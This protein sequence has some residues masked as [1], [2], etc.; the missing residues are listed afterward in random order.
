M[1]FKPW[2]ERDIWQIERWTGGRDDDTGE[3]W[4]GGKGK[5]QS[6]IFANLKKQI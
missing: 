5:G 1:Y 2:V 4:D 3:P 6:F